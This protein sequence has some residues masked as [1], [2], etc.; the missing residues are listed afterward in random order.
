MWFFYSKKLLNLKQNTTYNLQLLVRSYNAILNQFFCKSVSR[1]QG[2]TGIIKNNDWS[3][4][5]YVIEEDIPFT[6]DGIW[7]NIIG[8]ISVGEDVLDANLSIGNDVPNLYGI[9]SYFDIT[10]VQLSEAT[11]SLEW[12]PYFITPDTKVVQKYEHTLTAVWEEN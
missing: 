6:N 7:H 9:G 2:K 8:K 11:S 3:Q 4:P 5:M 12:E 1:T 10:Q